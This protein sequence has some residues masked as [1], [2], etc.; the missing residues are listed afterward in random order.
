MI[1]NET[2]YREA[3]TRPAEERQRLADRRQRLKE[4]GLRDEEIER[5][6]DPM[7]SFHFQL[8]EEVESYERLKRGEFEEIENLGGFGH[9]LISLRIV[10]LL[11]V[12][13][14]KDSPWL[15]HSV[16]SAFVDSTLDR[17]PGWLIVTLSPPGSPSSQ[18]S[19]LVRWREEPVPQSEWIKIPWTGGAGTA[20][21]RVSP[22]GNFFYLFE[23]SKLTA[24]RFDSQKD[25]FGGPVEVKY[26]PGSTVTLDPGDDWTVRGPGLVISREETIMSVWTMKLPRWS[27]PITG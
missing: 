1:R 25:S 13:S 17:D 24:V 22:S 26:A 11:D 8:K 20:N 21:W 15:E 12:A 19:Y 10:R 7:E 16:D 14:G 5:V 3:S 9:L 2:E 23:G 4:A 6:F 27:S 18:R